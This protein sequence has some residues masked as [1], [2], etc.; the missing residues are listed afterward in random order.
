MRLASTVR[1]SATLLVAV[2]LYLLI[3]QPRLR[4]LPAFG[5]WH[6]LAT[7]VEE[8]EDRLEAQTGH[9][10]RIVGDGKYQIASVVAFYRMPIESDPSEVVLYTTSQWVLGREGLGYR[11]WSEQQDW[12]GTDVIY[13]SDDDDFLR[14]MTPWFKSVEVIDDPRLRQSRLY[15]VA[16]GHH[17]LRQPT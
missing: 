5:P 6:E 9:E 11:F 14:E 2:L 15:H 7:V 16:V 3:L 17:L 10:P 13:V 12:V 1:V 4:L 8:Q